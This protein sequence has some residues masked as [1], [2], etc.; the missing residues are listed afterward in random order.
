MSKFLLTPGWYWSPAFAGGQDRS[1]VPSR[2][3]APFDLANYLKGGGTG[4]AAF[5]VT[6][7]CDGDHMGPQDRTCDLSQIFASCTGPARC[8]RVTLR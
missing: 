8:R 1:S 5:Y 7:E 3:L 2:S 4:G 6:R